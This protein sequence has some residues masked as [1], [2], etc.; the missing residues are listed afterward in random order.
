LQAART[1]SPWAI[2]LEQFNNVLIIILL[3]ATAVSAFSDTAPRRSSL[4]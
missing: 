4:R 2:L 1:I 3:I